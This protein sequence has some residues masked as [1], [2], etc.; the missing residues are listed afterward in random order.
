MGLKMFKT[1]REQ[2]LFLLFKQLKL[3]QRDCVCWS[4]G[5][6]GTERPDTLGIQQ[7]CRDCEP[8]IFHER[9]EKTGTPGQSGKAGTSSTNFAMFKRSDAEIAPTKPSLHPNYLRAVTLIRAHNSV[10]MG[11]MLCDSHYSHVLLNYP[12]LQFLNQQ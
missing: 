7:A 6:Q 3:D 12:F 8:T 5:D 9:G 4:L 10:V 1:S 11:N 2:S